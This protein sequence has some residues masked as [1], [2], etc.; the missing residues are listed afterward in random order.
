MRDGGMRAALRAEL[1]VMRHR[2]AVLAL[3]LTLPVNMLISSYLTDYV[4]YLTAG[5]GT[6]GD[7]FGSGVEVLPAVR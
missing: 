2:P 6:V 7:G 1:L 5:K 4:S 3:V